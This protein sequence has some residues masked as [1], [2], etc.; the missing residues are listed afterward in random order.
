MWPPCPVYA[1]RQ[2]GRRHSYE[3]MEQKTGNSPPNRRAIL[4]HGAH[5]G[6]HD[7]SRAVILGS[8]RC[9]PIQTVLDMDSRSPGPSKARLQREPSQETRLIWRA[10]TLRAASSARHAPR[11]SKEGDQAQQQRV[12]NDDADIDPIKIGKIACGALKG[13]AVGE[14]K[15]SGERDAGHGRGQI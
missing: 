5:P 3:R 11:E 15:G 2:L 6:G 8:A 4:R 7:G 14:D 1:A 12:C 13:K 9:Y 10:R